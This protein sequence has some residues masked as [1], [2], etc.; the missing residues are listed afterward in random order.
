MADVACLG[1]GAASWCCAV[2]YIINRGLKEEREKNQRELAETSRNL[3]QQLQHLELMN[4]LNINS[5]LVGV[6][7]VPIPNGV[8]FIPNQRTGINSYTN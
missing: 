2:G 8:I 7:A 4:R 3:Q 5:S 1:C 6:Q